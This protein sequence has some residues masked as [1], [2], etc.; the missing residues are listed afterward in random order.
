MCP[1]VVISS[2]QLT[3]G[4]HAVMTCS[5]DSGVVDLMEWLLAGLVV[6]SSQFVQTLEH[7]LDPVSDT[8]H[9]SEVTCLVTRGTNTV[10]ETQ[11]ISVIGEYDHITIQGMS[12]P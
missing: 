5:S 4:S 10:N 11:P 9:R 8:L 12:C 3:V 1:G 6:A 7:V 2:E